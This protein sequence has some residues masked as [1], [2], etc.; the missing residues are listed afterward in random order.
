MYTRT[1]DEGEFIEEEEVEPYVT[2]RKI[3]FQNRRKKL[4]K[5]ARNLFILFL[6]L[7]GLGA[8]VSGFVSL[9]LESNEP[10]RNVE[11]FT[12]SFFHSESAKAGSFSLGESGNPVRYELI[13]NLNEGW[14]S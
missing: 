14:V 4:K 12:L 11:M 5:A 8:A 10:A 3:G 2:K 13:N 7:S 6:I 9:L 1:N